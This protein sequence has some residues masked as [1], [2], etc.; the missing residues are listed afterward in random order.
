ML[1]ILAIDIRGI[2]VAVRAKFVNRVRRLGGPRRTKINGQR[3]APRRR[4]KP[5]NDAT[6]GLVAVSE[7]RNFRGPVRLLQV[8]ISSFMDSRGSPPDGHSR[9]PGALFLE[10]ELCARRRK[11]GLRRFR[12]AFILKAHVAA[13]AITAK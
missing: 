5:R 13:A 11:R 7:I 10:T 2:F 12:S 4:R 8:P 9:G 6:H 1:P 3:G